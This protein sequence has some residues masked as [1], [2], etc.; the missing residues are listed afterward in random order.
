MPNGGVGAK[1]DSGGYPL[2]AFHFQVTFGASDS[3]SDTSFQEVS[4]IGTELEVEP[5][6]EGGENRFVHQL[7]K[8]VKHPAGT[9]RVVFV[10]LRALIS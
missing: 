10:L 8:A 1:Q 6:A 4:G 2:P 3:G 9:I 7:P 5:F